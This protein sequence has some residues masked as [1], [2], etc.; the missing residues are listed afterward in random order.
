MHNYWSYL[1]LK[2]QGRILLNKALFLFFT[3]LP[4]FLIEVLEAGNLAWLV[5]IVRAKALTLIVILA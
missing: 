5:K 3:L 1:K 2:P 4:D